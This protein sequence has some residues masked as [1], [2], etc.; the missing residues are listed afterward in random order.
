MSSFRE[1]IVK[2]PEGYDAA[3]LIFGYDEKDKFFA[4]ESDSDWTID[5]RIQFVGIPERYVFFKKKQTE[6][7]I[8]PFA[9]FFLEDGKIFPTKE[10]AEGKRVRRKI[11]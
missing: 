7:N 11:F 10:E 5:S 6:K 4:V 2:I 3:F 8:K 1:E 9:S